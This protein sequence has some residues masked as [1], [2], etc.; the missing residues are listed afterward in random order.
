MKINSIRPE[1]NEFLQ[2]LSYLAKPPKSLNYIGTLPKERLP[3]VAIVGTRKPT[4]YGKE[5]TQRFA[6]ELASRGVVI[7]S[8]NALG[9]D[10][11]AHKAALEAGG[12]TLAVLGNGLPMIYPATNKQLAEAI[13]D[14]GGAV[15][16]EYERNEDARPHYFLERNRLVSGL[17][18]AVIITEA[19]ARSGTL[20]TAMHALEQ[21]KELF[22]VPGQITSPMSMGCNQLII[23]G[24]TPL[25]HVEQ[26][27]EAI[28]PNLLKP[29]AVL[30]LGS[31]ELETKII[32]LL[33]QGVRDGDEIQKQ[34]HC[35][36][37]ALSTA[38]TMLEIHG[39]VRALGANRWTLR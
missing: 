35:A 16:S 3:T 4:A 38:L 26:V 2:I 39:I 5:V 28:A 9:I 19:A 6:S 7:V 11:I 23:Q 8:G 13:V 22:V 32:G 10:A 29:Q 34:V 30:A 31:N 14:R 27:L 25:L 20:N 1:E 12:I 21:A 18:D 24:A 37:S 15:I 17:A 33:Q 36:A